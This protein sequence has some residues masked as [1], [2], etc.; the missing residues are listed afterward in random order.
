MSYLNSFNGTIPLSK[1]HDL[2]VLYNESDRYCD[3][4]SA[5]IWVWLTTG[6][7]HVSVPTSDSSRIVFPDRAFDHRCSVL[8]QTQS[9]LFQMTFSLKAQALYHVLEKQNEGLA[10]FIC[11]AIFLKNNYL[12][13]LGVNQQ[14]IFTSKEVIFFGSCHPSSLAMFL[15][16]IKT[17]KC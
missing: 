15:C 6:I 11:F 17:F 5:L 3:W 2:R 12:L 14:Q 16:Q 10:A 1:L 9:Q 7:W 13:K 8:K 4:H